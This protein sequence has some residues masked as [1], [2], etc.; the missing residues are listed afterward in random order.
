MN[1]IL[2]MYRFVSE[3]ASM[4]LFVIIFISGVSVLLF[5]SFRTYDIGYSQ[6]K[7]TNSTLPAIQSRNIP[8]FLNESYSI[9]SVGFQIMLPGGW[10]GLNYQNIAMISP[11]GMHLNNGNLGPNGDKIL[12]II[13]ALNISDFLEHRMQYGEIEKNGCRILSDKYVKINDVNGQELYWQCGSDNDEDKMINYIF[14]S[15]N[16]IIVV[17]LK[18][19]G[20]VFDSN[21]DKFGKT[22]RTLSIDQPADIR[23]IR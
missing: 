11:A 1:L 7:L 10:K 20:S 2:R 13:Q 3:Y 9:P 21:L 22:V 19:S 23:K 14:A 18:G 8:E 12:M 17:G 15:G 4:R 6:E 5:G 16:K